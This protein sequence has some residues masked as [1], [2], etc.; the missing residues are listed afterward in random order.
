[1]CVGERERE[2]ERDMDQVEIGT[3]E[4]EQKAEQ[5]NLGLLQQVMKEIEGVL[6]HHADHLTTALADHIKALNKKKKTNSAFLHGVGREGLMMKGLAMRLFHMG[7]SVHCIGDM[8][9]PPITRGD[10]LLVSAGPGNFAT[11]KALT[12]VAHGAG[13]R[14]VL[15]TAQPETAEA[16]YGGILHQI[17]HLPAPTM[18]DN[19]HGSAHLLPMGSAYE[20]ALFVLFELLII[21][22]SAELQVSAAA[23][24]ARH[25]NL[26]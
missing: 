10:L 7:I 16:H 3:G 23:M 24:S 12:E 11:V 8:T 21:K 20:G 15:L 13:A 2:R 4:H 17:L 6:T 1:M 19:H 18:A 5:Q 22:L 14:V 25:T 26:E 9:T